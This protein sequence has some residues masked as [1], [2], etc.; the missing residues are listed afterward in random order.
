MHKQL[1]AALKPPSQFA[2]VKISEGRC[3]VLQEAANLSEQQLQQF[4]TMWEEDSAV[5]SRLCE[6][7]SELRV[8]IRQLL[9]ADSSS[10][11]PAAAHWELVTTGGPHVL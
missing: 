1:G 3:L 7:E 10:L 9:M 2:C 5:I 11:P 4:W 6:R 8:H